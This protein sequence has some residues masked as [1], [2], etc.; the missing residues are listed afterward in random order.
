MRPATSSRTP[1]TGRQDKRN[2]LGD[3][4]FRG[5]LRHL[6]TPPSWFTDK[7]Q[8]ERLAQAVQASETRSN[9]QF[10]NHWDIALWRNGTPEQHEALARRISQRYVERYGTLVI[11]AIHAPS[12]QGSEHN[13]HLHLAPNMR[14]ITELG[15]G[16]KATE[17]T[18]GKTSPSET[19]WARRMIAEET[20]ALPEERVHSDE[21]GNSAERVSSEVFSSEPMVHMGETTSWQAARR[22]DIRTDVGDWNRVIRAVNEDI[23]RTESPVRHAA[24][25]KAKQQLYP[26]G[27]AEIK[28]EAR[29]RKDPNG[30]DTRTIQPDNR[31]RRIRFR[32][33][34]RQV[35]SGP[36]RDL[37]RRL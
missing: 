10:G 2:H 15:F 22:R 16:E 27:R 4:G 14:R 5:A 13:W 37:P 32:A 9:A 35:R 26:S 18:D 21:R 1:E 7:K 11:Y 12:G 29:A 30:A 36:R 19:E 34:R 25:Q 31:I 8:I 3:A 17:I 6:S 24:P 33:S 23:E 28:A 20:N